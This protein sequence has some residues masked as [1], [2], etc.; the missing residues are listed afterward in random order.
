MTTIVKSNMVAHAS[1]LAAR[2]LS[3]AAHSR[4]DQ[5]TMPTQSLPVVVIGMANRA[6][7]G[8]AEADG[9]LI[10]DVVTEAVA[11]VAAESGQPVEDVWWK[12]VGA[13]SGRSVPLLMRAASRIRKTCPAS[14]L[15]VAAAVEVLRYI[16]RSVLPKASD[17]LLM[18]AV[19]NKIGNYLLEYGQP[20]KRRMAVTD[21]AEAVSRLI[22]HSIASN[23]GLDPGEINK[24][25]TMRALGPDLASRRRAIIEINTHMRYS[26]DP[27]WAN[28]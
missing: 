21:S 10:A 8:I 14:T 22:V 13:L 5:V 2:C 16:S 25:T 1:T 11:A 4:S 20:P 15:D 26:N 7:Y 12:P 6:E 28:K 18:T 19:A 23:M 24:W 17:S 9:R 27:N 3:L